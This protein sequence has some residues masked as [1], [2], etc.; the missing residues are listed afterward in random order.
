MFGENRIN[1]RKPRTCLQASDTLFFFS[2]KVV[3]SHLAI[4][5]IESTSVFVGWL[6]DWL[7]FNAT[8]LL[9]YISYNIEKRVIS[10]LDLWFQQIRLLNYYFHEG[11]KLN[12]WYTYVYAIIACIC[13]SIWNRSGLALPYIIWTIKTPI[14]LMR[15]R[16]GR[17]RMVVDLQLHM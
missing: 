8:P 10:G 6:I 17:H 15:S 7:V 14:S 16:R 13:L 5:G 12:I 2:N 11:M 9:S 3:S 1:R 4:A